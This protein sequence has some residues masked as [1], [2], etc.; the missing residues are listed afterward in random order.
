MLVSFLE[1]AKI[2]SQKENLKKFLGFDEINEDCLVA[3]HAM[4]QGRRNGGHN[5]S[6]SHSWSMICCI[7]A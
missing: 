7:I 1:L 4:N 2:P 6:L 5:P 3:L